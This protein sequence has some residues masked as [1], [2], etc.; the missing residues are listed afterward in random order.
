VA[1]ASPLI[2]LIAGELSGDLLG[3]SLI[4]ALRARYPEA[5]FVGVCG[6]RMREAGCEPLASIDALSVMGL[7]EVLPAIPR[8]F[9]LRASLV[10]TLGAMR[11]DV[12]IGIDAP[13]FNLG[14]E[15]RLKQRGLHTV[16]MVSPTVWAWRAGRVKGIAE[17]TD[18]ILC[19]LP[20]E[21]PYYEPVQLPAHFIGHPL[22][23]ELD[24]SGSRS[25]A[26]RAL[27]LAPE[28]PV[29]AVLPGSRGGELKY[30]GTCMAQALAQLAA[31][32][33]SLQF[34]TPVA[35]PSLRPGLEQLRSTLA[36]S[37]DWTLVDGQSRTAMI[38]ADVVLLASGTATLECLLLRRPMVVAY[39]VS[40]VTAFLLRSLGLLKIERVSLPNLLDAQAD[41][42]ERLQEAATPAQLRADV[43]ELLAADSP[44][45][46]AQL[47]AFDRIAHTLCRDA[48]ARAAEIIGAG[49]AR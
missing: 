38:A 16:H 33:P 34:V 2:A 46:Q 39:K 48:A 23:D 42:V 7:A 9:K 24:G 31:A 40:A 43:Q 26:R 30:L 25:D 4:D 1:S 35:K 15:K 11:P 19:L 12:V 10:D 41:V 36:A 27:G 44:R 14:L 37:A 45:R 47:A 29:V 6:P 17:S 32:D 49:L 22:A 3:A 28:R 5:R 21:P 8:L 18:E 20:F 13:D